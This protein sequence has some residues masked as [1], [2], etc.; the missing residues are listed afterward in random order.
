[1]GYLLWGRIEG[2]KAKRNQIPPSPFLGSLTEQGWRVCQLQPCILPLLTRSL[3][4]LSSSSGFR[5]T[6]HCDE[7]PLRGRGQSEVYSLNAL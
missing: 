1:M 6:C 3:P 5:I 7:E 2:T 4:P